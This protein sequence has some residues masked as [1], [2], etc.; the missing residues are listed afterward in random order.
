MRTFLAALSMLSALPLGSFLPTE[1]E[2]KRMADYY[3]LVG[4]LFAAL[5]AWVLGIAC[6][7]VVGIWALVDS[8]LL[9]MGKYVAGDGRILIKYTTTQ[10]RR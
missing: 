7:L 5:F 10:T 4:A 3:P 9:L 2:L 1:E 8:I 6:G